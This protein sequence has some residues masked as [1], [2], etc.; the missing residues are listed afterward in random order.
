MSDLLSR[1]QALYEA[2][3]PGEWYLLE[4]PWLPRNCDTSIL[5]GSPDPHIAKFVCDFESFGAED[6]DKNPRA[7][8]D[9]ELLVT[10]KNFWPQLRAELEQAGRMRE[11]LEDCVGALGDACHATAIYGDQPPQLYLDALDAARRALAL[12][13]E[14]NG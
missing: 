7:W 8:A 13:E 1:L 14:P 5:A 11:A 10:L 6:E 12:K 3:S 2:S 9:A 4:S